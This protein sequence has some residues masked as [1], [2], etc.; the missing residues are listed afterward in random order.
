MVKYRYLTL[1]EIN[2]LKKNCC[3]A[4]NWE[5]VLVKNG[6]TPERLQNV[7]FGGTVQLGVFDKSI[8]IEKDL[9]RPSGI[10]NTY[11]YN[12][13]IGDN[14]YIANVYN[15]LNYDIESGVIIENVNS[16]MVDTITSFGNGIAINV[17]NEGGGREI[18]I[19][20]KM[21]AQIAYLMATYRHDREFIKNLTKMI[22]NYAQ[23]KKST[24]GAILT[25]SRISHCSIIRN[26]YVGEYAQINGALLLEE[27]TIASC[28]ED[29]VIIGAGV[30]ARE[31]II[32][33][34]SIIDGGAI[35]SRCFV[36][37]AVK[38]G[39]QFSAENS[40]IFANSECFHGEVC[41]I[42]G[43]PYTVTHHKSTLLI[44]GLFSFYNAGSGTNQSNH[45]YKLG[46]VH[47]GVLERGCKT[48]SFSYLLWPAR[49]GAFTAVIGKHHI[50][51]D[52]SD[53]PFSYIIEEEGRSFLIPAVN[54]VTSGTHRDSAKW[55]QRDR[56]KDPE[57]FDLI[58][59]ELLT[60]YTIGKILIG[61][62]LLKNLAENTKEK[63]LVTPQGLQIK[64]LKLKTRLRYYEM[65]VKVFIG[66]LLIKRLEDC[67]NCTSFKQLQKKI[68][69]ES[70][71]GTGPWIDM[72]GMLAPLETVKELIMEIN[73]A[74]VNSL[75]VLSLQLKKI[76]NDYPSLAWQWCAD[77][78]SNRLGIALKDITIEDLA[79]I[80]EEWSE[81]CIKLNNMI[82][83]DA[84]KEFDKSSQTSYGI[85]GDTVIREKDFNAVRGFYSEN[86]FVLELQKKSE[87]IRRQASEWIAFLQGLPVK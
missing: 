81:N 61:M 35:I 21:S 60:P 16:I 57:K 20:D 39:R 41:S 42:F 49:V 84:E 79:H 29:P 24:R 62:E 54:L 18:L 77:L 30:N 10:T 13:T 28:K 3:S 48:G 53:L 34:G 56:R 27:G 52:S 1:D 50:N 14:V 40:A 66:N 43:G 45:M 12:C 75:E 68:L 82:L 33:S 37:Q 8:E 87:S 2:I 55:P 17:I 86:K 71:K 59:F 38:I 70:S 80:I 67:K 47:Q 11:L 23:S 83:K 5:H 36:G 51:F 6:F 4:E 31:F 64:R 26:V 7:R 73:K 85:D 9:F 78:I 19:Y 15:L 69:P 25:G 32:Q 58:H 65:A 46:P 22:Q 72:A 76:Y 63:V 44:A 74:E